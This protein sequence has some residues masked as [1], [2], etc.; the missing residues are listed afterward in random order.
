MPAS[1]VLLSP[2]P[3]PAALPLVAGPIFAARTLG[4]E[5]R[6]TCRLGGVWAVLGRENA[7]V[8]MVGREVEWVVSAMP[9][10]RMD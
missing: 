6:E 9:E 4:E 5:R 8:A 1:R 10:G 2:P 7:M 3:W